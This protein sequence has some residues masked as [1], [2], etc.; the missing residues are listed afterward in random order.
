MDVKDVAKVAE[1]ALSTLTQ[2]ILG[3]LLLLSWIIAAAAIWQL[4]K[5]Q[6]ARVQDQKEMSDRLERTN[7][8]MSSA[9]EKFQGAVESLEKAEQTG[10]QAVSLLKDQVMEVANKVTILIMGSMSRGGGK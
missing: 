3:A 6:N 5:V 7:A 4:I 8:K 9:F 2:S 10:Q 1:P